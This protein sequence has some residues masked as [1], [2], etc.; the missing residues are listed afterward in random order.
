MDLF[1]GKFE[2]LELDTTI[3][4]PNNQQLASPSKHL[5]SL[6]RVL[7]TCTTVK[8]KKLL[9]LH[10]ETR[11]RHASPLVQLDLRH[12]PAVYDYLLKSQFDLRLCISSFAR[13]LVQVHY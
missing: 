6:S 5:L 9:T 4:D 3:D 13:H 10:H 2:S 1:C 11:L 7:G 8:T 12:L